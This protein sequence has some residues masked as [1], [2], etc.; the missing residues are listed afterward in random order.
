[1]RFEPAGRFP[2][3]TSLVAV[4]VM[5][6]LVPA[7]PGRLGAQQQGP[8]RAVVRTAHALHDALASGDSARVLELLADEVRVYESGHAETRAEYR[9]GH[10]PVDIEFASGTDREILTEHVRTSGDGMALYTSEYR[11][12]GTF[13]GEKV[14]SRGTETLVVERRPVGWRIVHVHW[15]SR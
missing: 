8:K 13:R 11:T 6:L 10:L 9:S 7:V 5:L 15:S 3:P 14:D 4:L 12:T 1:M 2:V